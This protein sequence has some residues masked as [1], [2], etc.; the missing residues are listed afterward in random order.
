MRR[1]DFGKG[2]L[3]SQ[4]EAQI[5]SVRKERAKYPVLPAAVLTAL[6]PAL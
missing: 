3:Y 6:A 4:G 2:N 1:E 5:E